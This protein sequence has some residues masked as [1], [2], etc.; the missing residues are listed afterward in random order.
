MINIPYN[1]TSLYDSIL[2]YSICIYVLMV[3]TDWNVE[4]F[5]KAPHVDLARQE[6]HIFEAEI[7][8][9]QWNFGTHAC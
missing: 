8:M 9:A 4:C 3:Y 1:Y 6:V 7:T 2:F 5:N